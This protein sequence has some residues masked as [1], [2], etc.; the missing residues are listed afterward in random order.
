MSRKHFSGET[1]LRDV[2]DLRF[3]WTVQPGGTVDTGSQ[4]AS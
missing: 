2:V 3:D 1:S 4:P